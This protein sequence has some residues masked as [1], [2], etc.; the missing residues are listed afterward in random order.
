MCTSASRSTNGWLFLGALLLLAGPTRATPHPLQEGGAAD[1]AA[2]SGTDSTLLDLSLEELMAV[3]VVSASKKEQRL[4]DVP[5]A[6]YVL[7]AED[8]RRSGVTNVPD[9]LRLVPGLS[10]AR[11]DTNKWAISARGFTD[12]F[13]NKMQVLVDGQTYYTEFFSGVFWDSVD[14]ALD[15]IERIEIIRGPGASV[16]GANAVNGVIN[17]ITK[18]SSRTLGVMAEAGAGHEERSKAA[19]RVGGTLGAHGF[20]RVQ[21]QYANQSSYPTWSGNEGNG[22]T[23]S[24][25]LAFRS[26]WKSHHGDAL[27]LTGTLQNGRVEAR[28]QSPTTSAPYTRIVNSHDPTVA[29]SFLARW[30]RRS[31]DSRESSL[32][33]QWIQMHRRIET[34]EN[35]E[36]EQADFEAVHRQRLA[37]GHE[38]MAGMGYRLYRDHSLGSLLIQLEPPRQETRLLSSFAQYEWRNG[39]W[40]AT[41]GS[42]FEKKTG[43]DWEAQ[44]NARFLYRPAERHTFWLAAS[45]AARTPSR[46]DLDAVSTA[47]VIPPNPLFPG[48]PPVLVEVSGNQELKAEHLDAYEFGYRVRPWAPLQLDIAT[49]YNVYSDLQ[50]FKLSSFFPKEVEGQQFLV[51]PLYGSN[52]DHAIARGGEIAWHA[53]LAR[54]WRMHGGY[55]HYNLD[56]YSDPKGASF[57][58]LN[59]RGREP[60][61][62]AFLA[63]QGKATSRLE[64]DGDLRYVDRLD[65]LNIP[66]YFVA[67]LSARYHWTRNIA[68]R[69]ASRNLIDGR[70]REFKPGYLYASESDIP[71]AMYFAVEWSQSPSD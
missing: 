16:W 23:Q 33:A 57:D 39:P 22:G 12:V 13:A 50:G 45:R 24:S 32:E 30:S 49:F 44:P 59:R 55:S 34:L 14:L 26:D 11:L 62:Q 58:A 31:G 53:E 21:G 69:I 63:I 5:A 41:V 20:Y 27:M 42:R 2:D 65:G 7:S 29:R 43:I 51:M 40:S 61:N 10:V 28:S 6:I 48:A 52:G 18:H 1:I 38:L 19:V 54:G 68:T 35:I 67:D 36:S 37:P 4:E 60:G 47:M 15:N 17:I 70:H 8:L 64:T 56:Q 3:K 66:A 46:V 9:A 25:R 71:T